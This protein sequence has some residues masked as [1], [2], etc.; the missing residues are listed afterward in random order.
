[1]KSGQ[2]ITGIRTQDPRLTYPSARQLYHHLH[3][4]SRCPH[5]T[6]LY[7]MLRGYR[8]VLICMHSQVVKVN[9]PRIID[10]LS[11]DYVCYIYCNRQ[12]L[13]FSINLT[14]QIRFRFRFRGRTVAIYDNCN[15]MVRKEIREGAERRIETKREKF[16]NQSFVQDSIKNLSYV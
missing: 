4:Y 3:S 5:F 2:Q 11:S 14:I 1:M 9:T 12:L 13:Q 7:T 6:L 15:R 8:S 10:V 16:R